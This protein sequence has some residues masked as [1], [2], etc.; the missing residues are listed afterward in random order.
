MDRKT[1]LIVPRSVY[2]QAGAKE[3]FCK[4][5]D[6]EKTFDEK[7]ITA[8]EFIKGNYDYIIQPKQF[9]DA[10]KLVSDVELPDASIGGVPDVNYSVYS[11]IKQKFPADKYDLVFVNTGVVEGI[12]RL[13][14]S[15]GL[16]QMFPFDR[17]INV[18]DATTAL[19]GIGLGYETSEESRAAC[20][21]VCKDIGI[22]YLSTEEVLAE[23]LK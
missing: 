20:I 14:T 9:F 17:H 8:E 11:L 12:C 6:I 7:I 21:R 3:P 2:F 5:E 4:P 10:T 22:E 19:Y 15:I 16:A 13:H 18:T 1:G 23:K